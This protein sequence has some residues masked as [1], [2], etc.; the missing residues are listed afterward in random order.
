MPTYL[1]VYGTLMRGESRHRHLS[2]ETFVGA[3]QTASEYGLFDVG[4]YPALVAAAAGRAIQGELWQ[5]SHETL[6]ALDDVE[7]V[8]DGLYARVAV[9]LQ[10][11]FEQIAAETYVFGH[12]VAG[13]PDLGTSW[14]GRSGTV[15]KGAG[16]DFSA[17]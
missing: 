10:P 7:G 3:A 16:V 8:A 13:L 11:P 12:S 1:F 15:L 2:G 17:G 6:Q 4:E 14:R 5:V 9:R